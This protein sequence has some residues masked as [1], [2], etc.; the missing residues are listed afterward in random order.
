MANTSQG[1]SSTPV[2]LPAVAGAILLVVAIAPLPYGYYT[3]LR[4]AVTFVAVLIGFTAA[5]EGKLGWL[6]VAIP[7]G[8]VWNPLVPI[9]FTRAAWAPLDVVAAVLLVVCGALLRKRSA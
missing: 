3:F 7:I 9:S 5:R 8:I 4:L 1:V 2:L 6:W